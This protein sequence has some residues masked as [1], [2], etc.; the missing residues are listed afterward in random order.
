MTE[1]LKC[2]IPKC[3]NVAR[4]EYDFVTERGDLLFSVEGIRPVCRKHIRLAIE[5]MV[6]D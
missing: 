4:T 2:L 1:K 6:R 3:R 5:E